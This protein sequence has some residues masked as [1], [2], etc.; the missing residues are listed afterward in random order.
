MGTLMEYFLATGVA[1][2][3]LEAFLDADP[4]GAGSVR[5][6]I[7]ADMTNQLMGALG[8][9]RQQSVGEVKRIRARGH[10]VALDRRPRE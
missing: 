5:D 2:R 7:A 3:K 6:Q 9:R 10:W 4:S 1:P 8:Q